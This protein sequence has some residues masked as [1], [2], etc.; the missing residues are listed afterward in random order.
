LVSG[1]PT[2]TADRIRAARWLVEMGIAAQ[3]V[4]CSLII[5]ALLALYRLFRDVSQS[6]AITMVT[7]FLVSVPLQLANLLTHI[8]ALMMTSGAPTLA[9][10]S[11]EQL[12]SLAYTFVRL[13][14]RIDLAQIY[15]GSGLSRMGSSSGARASSGVARHPADRRRRRVRRELGHVPLFPEYA[16]AVTSD[17]RARR[18]R[19]SD[20]GVA[21][22]LGGETREDEGAQPLARPG[23]SPARSAD[24]LSAQRLLDNQRPFLSRSRFRA[25]EPNISRL[26]RL[27]IAAADGRSAVLRGLRPRTYL[28]RPQLSF[29]VRRQ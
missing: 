23:S 9:A 28:T 15:W 4:N 19:D 29:R 7:L 26:C 14:A 1:D 27:T 20:P 24:G 25:R 8:A 13:H 17:A 21:D 10:F 5:L 2:A 11:K 16:R 22:R 18:R 12:D 6:L 3:L